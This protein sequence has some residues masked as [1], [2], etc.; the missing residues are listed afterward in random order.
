MQVRTFLPS[1]LGLANEGPHLGLLQECQPGLLISGTQAGHSPFWEL[2][3]G[4]H[5]WGTR[6]TVPILSRVG[7]FQ[8]L[9]PR[10]LM[11]LLSGKQSS[12]PILCKQPLSGGRLIETT[13]APLTVKPE[14]KS[15]YLRGAYCKMINCRSRNTF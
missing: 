14:E 7:H 15:F 11:T 3:S 13:L 4:I 5:S 6:T 12:G 9:N 8:P 2:C 10:G 1:A